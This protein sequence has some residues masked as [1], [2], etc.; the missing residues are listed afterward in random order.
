MT[1]AKRPTW[2]ELQTQA[3]GLCEAVVGWMYAAGLAAAWAW[4]VKG[5]C[6]DSERNFLPDDLLTTRLRA[7]EY[8]MEAEA[9]TSVANELLRDIAG[10]DATDLAM[11]TERERGALIC[12]EQAQNAVAARQGGLADALDAAADEAEVRAGGAT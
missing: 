10:L 6:S 3:P 8:R 12:A 4:L 11:L 1:D 9:A 5:A 2:A 7:A